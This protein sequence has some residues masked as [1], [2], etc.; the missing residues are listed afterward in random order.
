MPFDCWIGRHVHTYFRSRTLACTQNQQLGVSVLR[1]YHCT[2]QRMTWS[3][4]YESYLMIQMKIQMTDWI[5]PSMP[6]QK[7]KSQF[8]WTNRYYTRLWK[9]SIQQNN[10]LSLQ[11]HW[12]FQ[13]QSAHV[14]SNLKNFRVIWH[15]EFDWYWLFQTSKQVL[16]SKHSNHYQYSF[17]RQPLIHKRSK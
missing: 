14:G 12:E 7:H 5:Y 15:K 16:S 17:G 6:I 1:D 10:S 2:A 11:E 8:E 9:V 4:T 13:M 3:I